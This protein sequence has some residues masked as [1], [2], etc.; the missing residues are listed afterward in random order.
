MDEQKSPVEQLWSNYWCSCLH[1]I[2]DIL[3]NPKAKGLEMIVRAEYD[4]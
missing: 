4:L 3:R 2:K 1:N